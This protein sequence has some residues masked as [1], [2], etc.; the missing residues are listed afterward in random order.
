M[1]ASFTHTLRTPIP[2]PT[3]FEEVVA[4][5]H[6]HSR[7]IHLN[8]LVKAC[9]PVDPARRP[10]SDGFVAY[11]IV[12]RLPYVPWDVKY[13][14]W[15]AD[16]PAGLRSRIAAPGGMDIDGTWRVLR[17]PDGSCALE[18]VATVRC[19]ALVKRF[20]Q[21]TIWDAHAQLHVRFVEQLQKGAR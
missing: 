16:E 5:L 8:P 10:D 4:A 13:K 15:L 9:P 3:S 20:V 21:N 14:A 11:T 18:E 1:P 12:D 19:S 6:D 2:V 7:F 17:E